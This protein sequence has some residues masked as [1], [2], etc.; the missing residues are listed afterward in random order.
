MQ[1]RWVWLVL[2][3]PLWGSL[4]FSFG[5][6]PIVSR[7]DDKTAVIA[8]TVA[9]AAAA[10][11]PYVVQRVGPRGGAGIYWGMDGTV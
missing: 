7:T 4:F 6:G 5:L 9:F 11:A 10:A 2:F 3:F 1:R 8:N